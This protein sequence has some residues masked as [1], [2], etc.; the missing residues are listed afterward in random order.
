MEGVILNDDR[1][2][3]HIRTHILQPQTSTMVS[4]SLVCVKPI[5]CVQINESIVQNTV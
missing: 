5:I 4:S 3:E 1:S 2:I